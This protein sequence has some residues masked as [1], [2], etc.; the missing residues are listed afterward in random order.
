MA[1]KK[2]GVLLE[3]DSSISWMTHYT[4]P[5]F[6][7]VTDS[8]TID[9]Y[10]SGRDAGNVSRIG[11]VKVSKSDPTKIV[12]VDSKPIFDIG[13]LGTFDENG[14][15][16]PWIVKTENEVYLYYVGWVA[17]GR[18]GFQNAVGLCTSND[19]GVTFTR[20]SRAPILARI[21]AEPIGTGSM[22]VIKEGALW[23]MWY[24]SFDKWVERDDVPQHYYNIKYA[25]SEDGI[26]W[27]RTGHI[28]IDYKSDDE[29]T[30]CKPMVIVRDGYYEMWYSYR[31]GSD[32]YRIGYAKS[33]DGIHWIRKDVE[34]AIDVSESGW[35]SEMIE[36]A[37]VFDCNEKRYMIYN[38]NSFG[39]SG[40]GIAQWVD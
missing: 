11:V 34:T 22:C 16:Y 29:H 35:D 33:S 23:R 40:L 8:E 17:G 37:Y 27:N 25:V 2:Y 7:D 5:S 21:D 19:N 3:P 13:E 10:L 6:A 36:Y 1:W 32:T 38:G 4:G 15:A 12:S 26:N 39:K 31:G 20:K 24:T 18:T 9:I 30:I 14:V 28:A